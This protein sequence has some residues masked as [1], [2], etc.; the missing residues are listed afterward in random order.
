MRDLFRP[1]IALVLVLAAAA[2][3]SAQ[4]TSGSMSG[5]VVDTQDQVVPGA[6]VVLTNQQTQE[7]RRTVTNDVGLF[8]FP[9]LQPG[10]YTVRVELAGFRPIERRDNM[11]VSNSRLAVPPLRLEVGSLSEAVTVSAVGEVIATSQTS[12][13][14]LLDLKQ[15]ENLSIRGRDPISFLKVLPGVGL[16]AND[17]ETF[18][19]SF[20]TPVPN[21]QGGTRADDL[22]RWRQRW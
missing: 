11:V 14:A 19:G 16:L 20:S 7:V 2:T 5:T 1:M 6:D 9:A 13:M 8:T 10:P 15:V 21:I 22:R 17:Q 4:T 18:G 3:A 12:Q